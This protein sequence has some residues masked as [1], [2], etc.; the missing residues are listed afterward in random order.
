M[1]NWYV[2]TGGPSAG[3]TT[4]IRELEKLGYIVAPEMATEYIKEELEKGRTIG[5]ML[6]DPGRFQRNILERQLAFEKTLPQDKTVILDRGMHDH[7]GYLAVHGVSRS[8]LA[9]LEEEL[10]KGQYGKVFILDLLPFVADEARM[11]SAEQGNILA[12][13]IEDEI[14]KSYTERGLEIIR[15]PVMPVAE[16]LSVILKHITHE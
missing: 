10:A 15:I 12:Q 3:K 6:Q 13:R 2:L 11:E 9:D 1:K 16:R 7:Y 8:V 5:E 4:I 14:V